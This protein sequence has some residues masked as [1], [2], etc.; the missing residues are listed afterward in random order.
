[1][2]TQLSSVINDISESENDLPKINIPKASAFLQQAEAICNSHNSSF[3]SVE[4]DI[5]YLKILTSGV[6][7]TPFSFSTVSFTKSISSKIS[8][9]V[10]LS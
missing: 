6:R 2:A 8:L 10:A 5:N 3:I 1:M 4:N 7:R 9:E